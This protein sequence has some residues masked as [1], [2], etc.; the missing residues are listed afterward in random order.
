MS[1]QQIWNLRVDTLIMRGLSCAEAKNQ[2][3]R[4]AVRR[5]DARNAARAE[6]ARVARIVARQTGR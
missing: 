6:N 1:E 4:E 3:T 5:A 2:A